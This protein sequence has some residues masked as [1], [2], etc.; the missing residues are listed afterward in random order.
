MQASCLRFP[1]EDRF[2]ETP[3]GRAGLAIAGETP[4]L[5]R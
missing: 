5:P 1:K 2:G 3:K 4:A